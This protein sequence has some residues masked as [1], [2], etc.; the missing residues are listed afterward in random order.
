MIDKDP[1][2]PELF[3][4]EQPQKRSPWPVRALVLTLCFVVNILFAFGSA[5]LGVRHND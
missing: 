5:A 2:D 4:H 3:Y 1:H